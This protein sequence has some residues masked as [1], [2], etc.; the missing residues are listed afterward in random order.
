MLQGANN[1]GNLGL[2]P[3]NFT[4]INTPAATYGNKTWV[5]ID[6]AGNYFM[7]GIDT[8]YLLFCW[9]RWGCHGP[10]R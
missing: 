9:V 3:S 4:S 10:R 7:C 5:S 1:Y 6:M 2:G 8:S